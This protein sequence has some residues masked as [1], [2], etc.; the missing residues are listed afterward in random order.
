MSRILLGVSGGIAAY[1]AVEF[2]R[3]AT[4]AGHGVRVLMTDNA[5]R[6]VGAATFEGI[7]GAPVL[8]S[9]FDSDPMSGSFPGEPRPDHDPISHLEVVANADCFLVAPASAGTIA[10]LANG[11][12]DSMLT[13]GFL[14]C[15]APRLVAP[16]MNDRMYRDQ[17]VEANIETLRSRGVVILEP[18]SGDLASRGEQGV[19]RMQEPAQLLEAIEGTLPQPSGRW[20]GL[21]VLVSAGG[22]REPVDS[23]R[24]LG[25]RSSGQMG[26]ALAEQALARGAS[27][28]VVA[29][30]VSL[31]TSSVIERVDV[32]TTSEMSSA[33]SDRFGNCDVLLM[34]AAPAD[35]TPVGQA[36]AGKISRGE[37]SRSLDLEPTE[38]IL[39]SLA[40]RREPGQT[41]IGFA[42]EI[43]EGVD[44]AR[45]KLVDKGVD[46]IVLNDVSRS[47]IGFD[48]SQNEV[49]IVD[50]GGE[51]LVP[52]APKAEIAAAVLDRVDEIRGRGTSTG[53][54]ASS[55]AGSDRFR[56]H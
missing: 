37:G 36:S 31:D 48:S 38:D 40:A 53:T 39:S 20:D 15:T 26:F 32:E 44:R 16:A 27:V 21:K 41:L 2:V 43:G 4:K 54:A 55:P 17:A 12:A 34:A 5:S 30:N 6:F 29:A 51:T 18:A 25:N 49:L 24:F 9:E 7:T 22:T 28:T 46:A 42:A 52:L 1:K 45:K 14:A 50:S 56:S 33:L 11:F 35:F 8:T 10:K 23:V 3:L 13:T 19:G 47:E